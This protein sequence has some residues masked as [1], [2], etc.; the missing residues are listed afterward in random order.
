MDWSWID[1]DDIEPPGY[2]DYYPTK[3]KF[4]YEK[5]KEI[6]WVIEYKDSPFERNEDMDKFYIKRDAVFY[7]IEHHTPVYKLE[8]LNFLLEVEDDQDEKFKIEEIILLNI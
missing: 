2:D 7:Y 6:V 3:Y 8:L 4:E 5:D 1:D